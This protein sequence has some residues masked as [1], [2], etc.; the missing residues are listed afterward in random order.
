[1]FTSQRKGRSLSALTVWL[2][3]QPLVGKGGIKALEVA[4]G[5]VDEGVG[6]ARHLLS[7]APPPAPH[8]A[9]LASSR[10]FVWG[11][12]WRNWKKRDRKWGCWMSCSGSTWLSQGR[13]PLQA[14]HNGLER[15]WDR[16]QVSH[17]GRCWVEGGEG[18]LVCLRG[19]A[20]RGFSFSSGLMMCWGCAGA[21]V[22]GTCSHCRRASRAFGIISHGGAFGAT[23]GA[24]EEVAS[25]PRQHEAQVR[26]EAA[27]ARHSRARTRVLCDKE[28]AKK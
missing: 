2:M 19:A 13:R 28:E 9:H 23:K 26:D 24:R 21:S 16:T 27:Q 17:H 8:S 15:E 1:V 3:S 6:S 10:Q 11:G 25:V 12:F 18:Q 4:G 7:Q 20:R 22:H 14:R 5:G